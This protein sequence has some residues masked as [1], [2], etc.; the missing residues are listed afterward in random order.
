M[1]PLTATEPIVTSSDDDGAR[2]SSSSWGA[3]LDSLAAHIELQEQ[4]LRFGSP[5][6]NDLEIDPPAGPLGTVE[7]QRA[8]A[9]FDRCEEL[10]DLAAARAADSRGRLSPP[11][12]Y[13]QTP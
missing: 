4:A 8:I 2:S 6:P 9:L 1:M 12:P 7:R 10:L 5:A 3:V 13:R 11:S